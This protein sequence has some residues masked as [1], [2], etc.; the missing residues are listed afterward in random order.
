MLRT[1]E[2]TAR[3]TVTRP[4]E[5]DVETVVTDPPPILVLIDR[6]KLDGDHTT[7]RH[8]IPL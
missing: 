5:L 8:S 2:K 3:E 4:D 1:A 6:S 7:T